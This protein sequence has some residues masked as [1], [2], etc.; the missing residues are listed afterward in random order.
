MPQL[1]ERG[2][3]R[4][5]D[6]GCGIGRHAHYLASQGFSCVG[7]DASETGLNYARR[8]AA[9][10]G[11]TIE[12]RSGPFYAVPFG[13][14]RFD[15]VIAWNVIYHGDAEVVARTVAEIRRVLVPGGLYVGTQLSKRNRR[16]GLGR[17]VR[18]DT[19]VVDDAEG[20]EVHP[21]FYCDAARL[22]ELHRGFEVLELRDREQAPGAWHWEHTLERLS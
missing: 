10:A 12:Y 3:L 20:D 16:Y 2:L 18:P 22:I 9:L 11:L 14:G 1:R 6:L 17:E 15:L 4:V 7:V 19:F 5:L 21:H 8:Q 13:D